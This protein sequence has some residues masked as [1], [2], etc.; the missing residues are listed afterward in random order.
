M[1]RV[2]IAT[3]ALDPRTNQPVLLLKPDD[4]ERI[5]PI[6]LGQTEAMAILVALQGIVLPRPMTHDLFSN[7]IKSLGATLAEV[8][9]TNYT[10]GVFFAGL[11]LHTK[12]RTIELDTRP[13]DAIALAIRLGAPIFVADSV[14]DTV[15]IAAETLQI[16]ADAQNGP[17]GASNP[18]FQQM[19]D[20]ASRAQEFGLF[21]QT[22]PQK[23]RVPFVQP[24]DE[25]IAD[26]KRFID[27]TDPDDFGI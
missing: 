2:D 4:D 8:R 22:Q 24:T 26:F 12:G 6:S 9:I 13:S 14:F 27:F 21:G 11:V 17:D 19:A 7:V 16:D 18:L 15:S 20:M 23:P 25:E 1:I 3:L 5:L 10:N